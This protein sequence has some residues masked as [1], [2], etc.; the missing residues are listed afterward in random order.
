MPTGSDHDV[1]GYDE[2]VAQF[3]AR[4]L[5]ELVARPS[6]TTPDLWPARGKRPKRNTTERTW[7]QI[8]PEQE[9]EWSGERRHQQV[10]LK[11]LPRRMRRL[12]TRLDTTYLR[13]GILDLVTSEMM[14][15]AAEEGRLIETRPATEVLVVATPTRSYV[16]APDMRRILRDMAG[17]DR[18]MLNVFGAVKAATRQARMLSTWTSCELPSTLPRD[19]LRTS[20]AMVVESWCGL[21][22][23][24][25]P[26]RAPEGLLV[27]LARWVWGTAQANRGR[28]LKVLDWG[29]GNSPFTRAL[30]AVKIEAQAADLEPSTRPCLDELLLVDEVDVL[31]DAPPELAFVQRTSHI[32]SSRHY[33]VVLIQ[34]PPPCVGRA[35]YRDRFKDLPAG[36]PGQARLPDLGRRGLSRWSRGTPR[37]VRRILAT[38]ASARRVAL[39][40]PL[41][42]VGADVDAADAR[43]QGTSEL[44]QELLLGTHAAIT[45]SALI[46]STET[47][48]KWHCIVASR[49]PTGGPGAGLGDDG[50]FDLAAL[51]EALE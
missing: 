15:R 3:L 13:G 22:L 31:G 5:P 26:H 7:H 40:V 44:L 14:R 43:L 30:L 46:S 49:R 20:G 38:T 41:F 47:S 29:S 50:D 8:M 18:F 23:A 35:G 37:V 36:N 48:E 10:A 19:R 2:D 11:L 1:T 16:P 42:E 12:V 34:L 25:L 4:E 51:I 33:D 28:A 39:L 27:S 32:P 6:V 21:T 17:D 45:H 9:C 24:R